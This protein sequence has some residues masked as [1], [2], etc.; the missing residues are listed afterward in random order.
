ML[1][2]HTVAHGHAG[3]LTTG[4]LLLLEVLVVGHLLLLLVGHIARVH[5]GA[6]HVGLRSVDIVVRHVL[7]G[8]GGNIG[9]VD[10][11]LAGCR[12]GGVQASLGGG[13]LDKCDRKKSK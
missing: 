12:V 10:A 4:L 2:G 5:S 8:L 6:T 1:R 13:L 9:S 3:V 11:I 7:G